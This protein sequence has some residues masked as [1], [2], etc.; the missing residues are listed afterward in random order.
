VRLVLPPVE[1]DY[2]EAVFRAICEDGLGPAKLSDEER[3][4]LK[5][6]MVKHGVSEDAAEKE[7]DREIS[8]DFRAKGRD[9]HTAYASLLSFSFG[10]VDKAI[11]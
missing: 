1:T 5:V 3:A 8:Q 6:F 7:I 4:K 2:D 9:Y 10:T 11:D